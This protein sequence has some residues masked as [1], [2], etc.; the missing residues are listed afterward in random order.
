MPRRLRHI[1][2][3]LL[4]VLLPSLGFAQTLPCLEDAPRTDDF[5]FGQWASPIIVTE[6]AAPSEESDCPSTGYIT[7]ERPR[8]GLLPRVFFWFRLQGNPL[9]I[10]GMR[11]VEPIS[12]EVS[13]TTRNGEPTVQTIDVGAM[14]RPKVVVE[15]K[16]KAS[17]AFTVS[18]DRFFDWRGDFNMA[19]LG[20]GAVEIR[21][22]AGDRVVQC[23]PRHIASCK[24]SGDDC[25]IRLDIG[26]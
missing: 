21:L 24:C 23:R 3:S 11:E 13:G 17:G 8:F 20:P 15:Q 7:E 2:F 25:A 26:Q 4:L 18:T 22:M 16:G 19:S 5:R 12:V 9:F 1:F 6:F 14:L 10:G